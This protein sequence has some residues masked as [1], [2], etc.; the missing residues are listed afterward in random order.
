M[1]TLIPQFDLKNGGSTPTGAVNRAI[2]LKLAETIS[3][4]DFGA[5]GNGTTDDTASCQA[6]INYGIANG[7]EV[8]FP[9]G[10]YSVSTLTIANTAY[11]FS[12]R[13]D[14]CQFSAN[15][16]SPT[17]AIIQLNN[18]IDF[19][20]MGNCNI[21][22]ANTNYS[23]GFSVAAAGGSLTTTRV[24]IYNVTIRS[25]AIGIQVGTYNSDVQCSEINFFGCNF[26]QCCIGVYSTGTQTLS[27]WNGCNITAEANTL[28]PSANG[29]IK[30]IW[31]EGSV[32][33]VN[34][35]SI[36][37][38]DFAS[39]SIGI[40]FNPANSATYSNSYG[41]LHISGAQ[42]ETSNS[43]FLASNPRGLTTPTSYSSNVTITNCGG[44]DGSSTPANDFISCSDT[45]YAGYIEVTSCNFYSSNVRTANSMSSASFLNY[46]ITDK[47]SFN[48]NFRKWTN[49]VSGGIMLHDYTPAI[50]AYGVNTTIP[51]GANTVKFINN[52]TNA[53]YVRYGSYYSTSTGKFTCPPGIYSAQVNVNLIG[54]SSVSG[55][56]YL[57][58][59]GTS[60]VAHG[61]YVNGT[62]S[63]NA[64][65]S[66]SGGDT[67]EIVINGASGNTFSNDAYQSLNI[68]LS[69]HQ[70]Y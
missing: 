5:T 59:N 28:Y 67:L 24:N 55:D 10:N 20:W 65:W 61:T 21:V 33:Q 36:V 68:L 44:Y 2:N 22:V 62:A 7:V 64:F 66:V 57:L 46:F 25:S 27:S 11:N 70:P 43:L 41:R 12:I 34:G 31:L 63:L 4:K 29:A 15:A 39:S 3:V 54:G 53:E 23:C 45:T 51:S 42:I 35:G 8:V 14:D 47:T 60:I 18:V 56:I 26:F 1:T 69:S 40:L 52:A 38:D 48:K 49:G 6:A 17:L 58:L 9:I 13:C 30:A 50:L 32:V 19:S 16:T 37:M